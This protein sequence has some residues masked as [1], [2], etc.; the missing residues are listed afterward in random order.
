MIIYDWFGIQVHA[1]NQRRCNITG[2]LVC[3]LSP[4]KATFPAKFYPAKTHV[5][6][7]LLRIYD[8]PT[9]MWI[10]RDS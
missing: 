5:P 1:V 2:L 10:P 6:K 3:D 7:S 9:V 4:V 8:P